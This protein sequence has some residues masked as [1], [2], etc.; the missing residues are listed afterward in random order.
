M[1]RFEVQPIVTGS[2]GLSLQIDLD[3]VTAS[4]HVRVLGVIFSSDLS[5]DKHV[6]SVCAACFYWITGFANFD[7]FD[8]RRHWTTSPRRHLS[9]LL[10]QP[11]WTTGDS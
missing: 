5:L 8:R 2:R 1:G 10:S 9:T 11:G 3:T 6:S 4:D 7:E